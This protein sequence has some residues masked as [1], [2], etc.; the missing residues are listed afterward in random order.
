MTMDWYNLA[1]LPQRTHQGADWYARPGN[2][3]RLSWDRTQRVHRAL[4]R[5]GMA[6]DVR[7]FG[8]HPPNTRL[9]RFGVAPFA[10]TDPREFDLSVRLDADGALAWEG[11]RIEDYRTANHASLTRH[12]PDHQPGIPLHKITAP[13]G[14][15]VTPAECADA[16]HAYHRHRSQGGTHPH[17]FADDLIRFLTACASAAGFTVR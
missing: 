16:V 13:D 11:E 3:L 12:L 4:L 10:L 9:G 17:S 1:T 15:I 14:W 6:Y 2:A 7:G 5:L 8:Y